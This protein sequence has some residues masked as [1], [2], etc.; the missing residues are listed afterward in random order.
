MS[1]SFDKLTDIMAI[2]RGPEGCPW[3]HEQTHQSIIPQLIEETYELIDAIESKNNLHLCEE[4]GDLLLHVVFH[5]QMASD[6]GTFT[7]HDVVSGLSQKLIRRHP[8]VFGLL[9]VRN[10]GDVIKNWDKIKAKEKKNHTGKSFLDSVPKG[11]PALF[12]AFK[13]SKKASKAGFD[14]KGPISRKREDVSKKIEEEIQE[15][16]EALKHKNQKEIEHEVGDLFFALTN[17]CRFIGVQPEETLRAAN[18]RFRHRFGM[19]EKKIKMKRRSPKKLTPHE[20]N[21]LWEE[22]KKKLE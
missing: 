22:A 2:L 7:I 11:L 15:L 9:K 5:A 13:L 17:L 4:L 8:H 3:D 18:N 16:K 21:D 10:A 1:H 12:Q 6:N 19:M 14:W 20:W